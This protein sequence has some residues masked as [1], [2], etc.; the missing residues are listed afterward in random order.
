[1][2]NQ[3]DCKRIFA[4]DSKANRFRTKKN[5]RII[6]GRFAENTMIL[7]GIAFFDATLRIIARPLI[8]PMVKLFGAIKEKAEKETRKE[9]SNQPSNV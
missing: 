3:R 9:E 7:C 5:E 6:K 2:S 4:P 1:M 8:P